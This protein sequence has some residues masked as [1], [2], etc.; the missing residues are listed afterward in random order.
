MIFALSQIVREL[1]KNLTG[2][3]GKVR[4]V[5]LARFVAINSILDL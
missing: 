5:I 1:C 3:Q 4:E 2:I